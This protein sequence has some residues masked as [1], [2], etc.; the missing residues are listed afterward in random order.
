M[1]Q[2]KLN[3]GSLNSNEPYMSLSEIKS[4]RNHAPIEHRF[5][6]SLSR[7]KSVICDEKHANVCKLTRRSQTPSHVTDLNHKS[8]GQ[9]PG[10]PMTAFLPSAAGAL[11]GRRKNRR[12]LCRRKNRL[13]VMLS[14]QC[15]DLSQKLLII[16]VVLWCG[17]IGADS[18]GYPAREG[19]REAGKGVLPAGTPVA[20]THDL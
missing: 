17:I 4:T 18:Q 7:R 3:S 8:A 20:Q 5:T 19:G 10:L 14:A 9:H 13:I 15:S 12:A 16:N 11:C 6:L 1:R 2:E